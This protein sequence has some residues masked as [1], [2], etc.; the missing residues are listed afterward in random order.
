MKQFTEDELRTF[1]H[2]LKTPLTTVSLY[3]EALLNGQVGN[4]TEEQEDYIQ[5]I[6]KAATVMKETVE[7]LR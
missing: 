2:E 7:T 1:R 3:S 6:Q 5:E 4:L